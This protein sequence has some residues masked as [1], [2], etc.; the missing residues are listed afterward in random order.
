VY[1]F[2]RITSVA[3][4]F[5]T[6]FFNMLR[7]LKMQI[8]KTNGKQLTDFCMYNNLR[9]TKTYHPHKDIHKYTWTESG[10]RSIIDY[11][12]ANEKIWSYV[13]DTISYREAEVDTDHCLLCFKIRLPK[14]YWRKV[15]ATKLDKAE[16]YKIQ[17]AKYK[18]FI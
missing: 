13:L 12:I 7:Y 5:G 17:S 9:I 3:A 1:R 16:K 6:A 18:A 11:I 2:F 15:K 14:K 4:D 10:N 8:I